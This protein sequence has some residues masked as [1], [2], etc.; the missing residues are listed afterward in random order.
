MLSAVKVTI[1][2]EEIIKAVKEMK[3]KERDAF[4]EDLLAATS[5]EYLAGIKESRADYK[6]GRMK[7]HKEVFGK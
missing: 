2:Q 5:P 7:T 3:K 6:A 1:S 4:L